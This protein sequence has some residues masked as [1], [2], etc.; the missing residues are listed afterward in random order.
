MDN[1]LFINATLRP[2]SRTMI[3]AKHVLAKLEGKIIEVNLEK[4]QIPALDLE[5]MKLRDRL[6]SEGKTD[7]PVFHY[8]HLLREADIIVVAA[9]YYDLS[10]PAS[11]K[12]FVEASNIVGIPY[13]YEGVDPTPLCR[14]RKLFY[15][16][17]AGGPILSD[18]FGYGYIKKVAEYFYGIQDFFYVKAEN[19]DI[20]GSDPGKIMIEAMNYINEEM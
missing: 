16:T 11:L 15:V 3:L 8:A 1:I 14:A 5:Q 19:L 2:E 6:S 17:T 13:K 12:N 7:D 18:E 20:Y 9:P 4:E 10:F